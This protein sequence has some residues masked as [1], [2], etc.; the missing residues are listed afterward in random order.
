MDDHIYLVYINGS[1]A[2][3]W[4][5]QWTDWVTVY[6][7]FTDLKLA[8]AFVDESE[9]DLSIKKIPLN[10]KKLNRQEDPLM[11]SYHYESLYDDPMDI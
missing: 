1:D 7:S 9:M 8:Q 11:E 2:D 10:P 5:E 4:E 3:G 6:G